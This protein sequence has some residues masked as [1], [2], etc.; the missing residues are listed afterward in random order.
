[1][2]STSAPIASV[3][4]E[5]RERVGIER[6]IDRAV[7]ASPARRCRRAR[8]RARR[9][10]RATRPRARRR[11][12]PRR[13]RRSA[14]AARGAA[15]TS[16]SPSSSRNARGSRSCALREQRVHLDAGAGAD[17]REQQLALAA[18]VGVDRA[19]G[20]AR[21][22]G[23]CPAA[24]RLRSPARRRPRP[25]PRAGGRGSRCPARQPC[26]AMITIIIRGGNAPVRRPAGCEDAAVDLPV[27]PRRRRRPR[28]RRSAARCARRP[29]SQSETLSAI[30]G[31]QVWLKFENLQFTGA[32]KERGARNFLAHL[33]PDERAHGRRRGLGRQPRAG[34]RLPR[35]PARHPGHDR[36]ARRHAVHEGLEHR[37]PRRATS[38][39]KAPT[40]RARSRA[41]SASRPRR[42]AT[43]VPAFDD[44]LV[45]AGQG[46]IGLELLAQTA[47]RAA[48][49]DR[50]AD[51]RRRSHLGHRGRGEGAPARGARSSACRP[52]ATRG[53][54]TRSGRGPG[55][56]PAARRSPRASRSPTPG[57]LTRRIVARARRRHRRGVGAT[58][59]G[60]DRARRRDREDDARRRGRRRAGRA[61]RV[62]GRRSA[63]RTWASC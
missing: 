46:T 37:A 36:H 42:G 32:F 45:I 13:S 34:R 52:R 20:E 38:C 26:A 14:A 3:D 10:G 48:R 17:R 16:R 62:S 58:H 41:R 49:H 8:A 1:M 27:T 19:G 25:R 44:P 63:T 53:C 33:S 5:A 60:G 12:A 57:E 2:R 51:R 55:R 54:C 30:T 31:A 43:L 18:E 40:T 6:G 4:A 23:R 15:R 24:G 39:W 56:R 7:D 21:R 35:P 59:R 47:R 9:A 61:A 22:R 50:R 11:A 28:R 29:T